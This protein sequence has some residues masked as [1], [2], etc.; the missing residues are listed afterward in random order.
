MT[1]KEYEKV[2]EIIDRNFVVTHENL[3]NVPKI[4]LTLKGFSKV[5]EELRKLIKEN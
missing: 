2:I 5:K 3:T 1:P 4:V